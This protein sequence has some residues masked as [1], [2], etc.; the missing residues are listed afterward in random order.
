MTVAKGIANGFPI[1][2]CIA[3]PEVADS[4]GSMTIS[5]FGGNPV[6]AAAASETIAVLEEED[7]PRN[8]RERGAELRDGLLDLQRKHRVIGDVR[9]LGLMVGVEIVADEP[10]GDRTP[11]AAAANRLLEETR[12][13]GLLIGKGGLTGNTLRLGPPLVITADEVTEALR[14]LGEAFA[15]LES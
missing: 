7:L 6:S 1:A 11:D 14:I 12:K 5:T 4:F 8:A 3:V 9:G 10:G 15:A 2:G 13:R